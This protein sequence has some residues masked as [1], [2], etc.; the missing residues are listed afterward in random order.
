M[1]FTAST[2]PIID[3]LDLGII[4]ANVTKFYQ[5]SCIVELTI[6]EDSTLRVNTEASAIKSELVFKGKSEGEGS[7]HIF[8][9]SILFKDL[10]KTF[11]TDTVEFDIQEDCLVVRSGKSKFNLPQVVS[12]E[13][14]ELDRPQVSSE[15]VQSFEIS[16][17]AWDFIKSHQLYSIAMSFIHPVYTNVWVGD[18]GD[19]LVGDFDNSIFT[20]SNQ[21][22]LP[23]TCLLPDTI[24]NLLTTVPDNSQMSY[25]GRSFEIS[26]NTDPYSYICEFL[27]QYESDEGVGTYSADL[28]LSLFAKTDQSIKVNLAKVLKYLSQARLFTTTNDATIN[29][30]VTDT[31]FNL[32]NEHVNCKVPVNN[33]F[34]PFELTFQISLLNDLFAHMD[35]EDVEIC[36]LYLNDIVSGISVHTDQ[37]GAV[38]S[39]VE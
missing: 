26:V 22:E 32:V 25:L 29:L 21:V 24:V 6:Q 9:D 2:K 5:K 11:E 4:S 38:L 8:V 15:T 39:G 13:D 17:S 27:P 19:V 16:K 34:G 28:V 31:S 1:K 3:G 33:P 35:S 36:P 18:T 37:M 12:G 7:Y 30:E 23:S 20:H 10:L 14:L